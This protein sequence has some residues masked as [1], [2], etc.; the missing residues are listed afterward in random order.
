VCLQYCESFASHGAM[1]ASVILNLTAQGRRRAD[2][3][4]SMARRFAVHMDV[5]QNARTMPAAVAARSMHRVDQWAWFKR[6]LNKPQ[7][8][9]G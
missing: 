9:H 8:L 1:S 4:R 7:V 5:D 3:R 2:Q 6:R